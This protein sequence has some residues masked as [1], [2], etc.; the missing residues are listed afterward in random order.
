MDTLFGGMKNVLEGLARQ[1]PGVDLEKCIVD[2]KVAPPISPMIHTEYADNFE[3]YAYKASLVKATATGV[4]AKLNDAG[5]TTHPVGV[6]CG[7]DSLGWH[8]SAIELILGVSTKG[9]WRLRLGLLEFAKR[10]R[11]TAHQLK[12]LVGH[13]TSRALPR[14][15]LLAVFGTAYKFIASHRDDSHRS[16]H[17]WESVRR[18]LAWA[19][20]LIHVAQRS[21]TA[22]RS[23]VVYC[24]DAPWWGVGIVKKRAPIS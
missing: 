22:S 10:G 5:L 3:S 24:F 20:H 7:R 4:K 15:E 9:M 18:E 8:F 23:P 13:F 17:P 2:K 16:I 19:A 6:T 12:I 11:G 1:V 14:R 21:L